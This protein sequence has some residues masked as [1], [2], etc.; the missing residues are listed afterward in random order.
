MIK[1]NKRYAFNVALKEYPTTIPTLWDTVK[2]T[3][4]YAIAPC[5]LLTASVDF[6]KSHPEMIAEDNAMAFLSENNGETYNRCHCES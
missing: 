1:N 5:S 2:G 3:F 6:R 4:F